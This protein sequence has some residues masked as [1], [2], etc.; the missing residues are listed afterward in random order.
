M[1]A[2]ISLSN[3]NDGYYEEEFE[4]DGLVPEG[5]AKELPGLQDEEA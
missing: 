2:T 3:L 5:A 4:D 1:N